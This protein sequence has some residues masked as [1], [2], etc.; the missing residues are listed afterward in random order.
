VRNSPPAFALTAT[1]PKSIQTRVGDAYIFNLIHVKPEEVPH[2]IRDKFIALQERLTAVEPKGDEGSV[3]A[4]V[5][6]MS[7]DDAV[8]LARQ[9]VD[10]AYIVRRNLGEE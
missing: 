6:Q 3:A 4:T 5:A 1:S 9:I 2:E 10:M 8:E 7:T